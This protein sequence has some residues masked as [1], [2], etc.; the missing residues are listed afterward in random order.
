MH[1]DKPSLDRRDF[2]GTLTKASLLGAIGL[3]PVAVAAEAALPEKKT[4]PGTHSF[5]CP[6]YLQRPTDKSMCIMWMTGKPCYSWVEL[7]ETKEALTRKIHN[8]TNG[9][10]NANTRLHRIR[11]ENLRPATTAFA[12]EKPFIFTRGNHETRGKFSRELA[13]YVDGPYYFTMNWGPVHMTVLDTGEDKEDAHPVYAGI[14]DFDHYR[15]MQAQWLKEVV[16]TPEFRKA[17]FRVVM[18][19]IPHYYSGDWHGPMECRKHFGP[20][21]EE[22]KID[23]FLAGHTHTFG[24]HLPVPGQHSYPIVI[25][26]GPRDGNRTLIK[27]KADEKELH[28]VM[29]K[30]D[31][32]EVGKVDLKSKR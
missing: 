8:T 30:D 26:G 29:L 15:E 22:H 7:G 16:K 3:S 31:G 12:S 2:L 1:Q 32:T 17:K 21:F 23:L 10:V 20:V 11:V 19:H 4:A 24:I 9:L 5:L 18:M 28:L 14:V 13:D 6:P 27:V 25:G